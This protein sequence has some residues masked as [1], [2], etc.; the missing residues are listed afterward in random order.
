MQE[1][2]VSAR[3]LIKIY[4]TGRLD[5]LAL[6]GV[7][8]DVLQGE[9]LAITGPSGCGKTTF[10]NI[11]GGIEPASAG[12]VMVNGRDVTRLAGQDLV[13][14]RRTSVGIVYQFFNLLPQ[15]SAKQNV[16]LPMRLLGKPSPHCSQKAQELLVGL[17]LGDR[18]DHRPSELSG[19]EQQRV[20]IAAAL[21]ND[22]PLILADEPT[23]EL[24]SSASQSVITLFRELRDHYK[25]TVIVATH[26]PDVTGMADRVALM[27][28]GKIVRIEPSNESATGP[29]SKPANSGPSPGGP[30]GESPQPK[31]GEA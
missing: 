3:N 27:K 22:P 2:V 17:G 13:Q 10:I 15:L 12:L 18:L 8:L 1:P 16:E 7:D 31:D 11:C 30:P 29:K 9:I 4:R 24:D 21:A 6:R 26:E 23:G 19:G 28:D 25:K 20:A 14:Y 5:I